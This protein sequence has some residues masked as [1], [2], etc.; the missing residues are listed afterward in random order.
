MPLKV[1]EFGDSG[2]VSWL[3]SWSL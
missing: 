2:P 3:L 1:E